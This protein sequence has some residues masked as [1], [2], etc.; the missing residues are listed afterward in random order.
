MATHTLIQHMF[1]GSAYQNI[2]WV[3][4][5]PREFLDEKAFD[6]PLI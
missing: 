1:A 4:N 3:R 6:V 2:D 5:M